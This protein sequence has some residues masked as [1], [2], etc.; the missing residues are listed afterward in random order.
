MFLRLNAGKAKNKE[1]CCHEENDQ[2]KRPKNVSFFFKSLLPGYISNLIF[3]VSQ[4]ANV[5]LFDR[6]EKDRA[7]AKEKKKKDPSALKEREVYAGD[8]KYQ[9]RLH[10]L[11]EILP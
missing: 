9:M 10:V 11:C 2:S 7:K 1:V 5:F 6:K 4:N 8:K 3:N